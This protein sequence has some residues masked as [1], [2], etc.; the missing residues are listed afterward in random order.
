MTLT[1]ANRRDN[2]IEWMKAWERVLKQRPGV[3]ASV[4]LVDSAHDSDALALPSAVEITHTETFHKTSAQ[5]LCLSK[6]LRKGNTIVAHADVDIAPTVKMLDAI[7]KYTLVGRTAVWL[8]GDNVVGPGIVAA[9]A[10]DMENS[11]GT[12]PELF[13]YHGC[14]DTDLA[15]RLVTGNTQLLGVGVHV[16]LYHPP[17]PKKGT[18]YKHTHTVDSSRCEMEHAVWASG[19]TIL[20]DRRTRE[21]EDTMRRIDRL[22]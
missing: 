6:A 3:P 12:R 10:E 2:L 14:E 13:R 16:D 15:V 4:C 7:V 18:F 20:E 17:H 8:R 11:G 19:L 9:F 22:F 21:C 1:T 5:A